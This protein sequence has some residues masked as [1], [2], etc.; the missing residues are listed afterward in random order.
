M[1]ERR[2]LLLFL[3]VV[4]GVAVMAGARRDE[5]TDHMPS[6]RGETSAAGVAPAELN[7]GLGR[8]L[9]ACGAVGR[10]S[11]LNQLSDSDRARVVNDLVGP[12]ALAYVKAKEA[13]DPAFKAVQARSAAL[14]HGRGLRRS[15][16]ARVVLVQVPK[17][18][19]TRPVA[20]L[21]EFF[22]LIVPPVRAEEFD[23]FEIIAQSW[24]DGQH[25]T[26]EGNVYVRELSSGLWMSANEQHELASEPYWG[27]WADLVDTNF[28]PRPDCRKQGSVC[29]YCANPYAAE[30]NLQQA[31]GHAWLSCAA[32]AGGCMFSGP[33]W[34]QC[35]SISCYGTIFS[36]WLLQTKQH[37]QQCWLDEYE[38]QYCLG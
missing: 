6:T 8:T 4:L 3:I 23:G 1:N 11:R 12:S 38:E 28:R 31:L 27:N 34:L 13:N 30:C 21:R 17:S 2:A 20:L 26:W 15:P 33:A 14:L 25:T 19:S 16:I 35:T 22:N 5:V 24:D 37:F 32:W 10:Q 36:A 18:G 29:G 7:A 9:G